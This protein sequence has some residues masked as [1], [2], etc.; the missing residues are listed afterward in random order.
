MKI[1]PLNLE[2]E[3]I[4]AQSKEIVPVL[5]GH[6]RASGHV[7]PPKF[8]GGSVVIELVYGGVAA[9]YALIV[10]EELQAVVSGQPKFL[11]MPAKAAAKGMGSRIAKGIFRRLKAK[12]LA[13]KTTRSP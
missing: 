8:R 12:G 2:G 5:N 13:G 7:R 3:G 11:E 4:M 9:P 1:K 10:H 6:L